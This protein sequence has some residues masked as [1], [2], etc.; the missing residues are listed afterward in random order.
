MLW[1]LSVIA[2]S[3]VSVSHRMFYPRFSLRVMRF[4][5]FSIYAKKPIDNRGRTNGAEC[6]CRGDRLGLNVL[7][8]AFVPRYSIREKRSLMKTDDITK[9]RSF[10]LQANLRISFVIRSVSF[11]LSHY[12]RSFFLLSFFVNSVAL[13][14]YWMIF[15]LLLLLK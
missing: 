8:A 7:P 6:E 11:F 1:H 4:M 2:M 10:Y 15:F 9:Q 5:Q 13:E 3:F 12:L 14:T